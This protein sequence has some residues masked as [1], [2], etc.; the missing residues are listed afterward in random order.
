MDGWMD[1]T[2]QNTKQKWMSFWARKS[3]QLLG[4]LFGEF[5]WK[6]AKNKSK[7]H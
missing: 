5:F 1:E 7:L 4:V 2:H 6:L 3:I